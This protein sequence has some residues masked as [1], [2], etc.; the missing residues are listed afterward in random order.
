VAF[1]GYEAFDDPYLYKNTQ[2]L[3]N[4]LGIRDAATLEAFEVEMTS[5]RADE[6]LPSGHFDSVHYRKIHRHLFQDV[7]RWAG[8]Y[9]S[10]RITKGGNPFC[11]PEHIDWQMEQLFVRLAHG[12]LLRTPA[13]QTFAARAAEFLSE[14]N[15]VHPFREG[16]GRTQLA[17]LDQVAA[18]VDHPM[19]LDQVKRGT[20]LPAM[21]A[22]FA[23]DLGP[24]TAE[25]TKLQA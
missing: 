13:F 21:I 19:R 3:K 22:S 16:N 14:L 2:V 9:R 8:R 7:Y 15:A 25:L 20:F 24:L 5:L 1:E 23:G 6:P 18:Y 17:F 4:R 12:E 11:F 10:V